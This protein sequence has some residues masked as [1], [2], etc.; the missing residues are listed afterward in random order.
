[1]Q[2]LENRDRRLLRDHHEHSP[3]KLL[4]DPWLDA[5]HNVKMPLQKA[6]SLQEPLL[7]DVALLLMLL[8][9]VLPQVVRVEEL[10]V[11]DVALSQMDLAHVPL[12]L[13]C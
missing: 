8:L 7:A 1:M 10:G 9:L 4:D 11:A 12:Q 5:M 13:S 2:T 3:S 6:G